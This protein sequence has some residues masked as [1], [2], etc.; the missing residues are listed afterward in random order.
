[1]TAYSP[2]VPRAKSDDVLS[3][4]LHARQYDLSPTAV[5]AVVR[6]MW[7]GGVLCDVT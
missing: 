3:V 5:I 7:R 2:E 6:N 1:M 4:E